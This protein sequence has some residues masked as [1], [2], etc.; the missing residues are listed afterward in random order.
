MSLRSLSVILLWG[1]VF[2]RVPVLQAQVVFPGQEW[3]RKTPEEV[4][5]DPQKLERLGK[6]LGG[7]GCVVKSGYVIHTWGD[8][9]LRK[10]WLSSAKPVLSTLLFFAV[11][12]GKVPAAETKLVDL[13]W[14]LLSK[15]REMQI[16]HL[17][18]MVSGYAR[19]EAPGGAWAYN[20]FAIQLY[21][22]TLFQRIFQADAT[23]VANASERFGA[24]GLQDGLKFSEKA[25]LW[26]SPRDFA[27]IGWFW[28]HKGNWNGK[29]ILKQ[30]FFDR[31]QQPY[32][33]SSLPL[34]DADIDTD[35]Y[36]QIGSYGG[37]SNHFTKA[38]PGI[39][40][41]NWWFNARKEEPGKPYTWPDVPGDAY[42]SLG[43]GGNCSIVIPS[44][45]V[46]VAAA[47]ANWGQV[48]PGVRLS[49]LNQR[50][51]LLVSAVAPETVKDSL[52]EAT[53]VI[54]G[55]LK[56]WH[57]ISLTFDGP[58]SDEMATPNP[59]RD[60]RLIVEFTRP[61]RSL[62]VQGFFA[63]DGNAAETGATAGNKWRVHFAPDEAGAWRYQASLVQGEKVALSNDLKDG[64]PLWTSSGVI[65]VA[66][67]DKKGSDIRALGALRDVGQRYWEFAENHQVYLK[68]G[69]DSPEN[70]LAFADF[71]G[72]KP[73]HKYAP[74]AGDFK[75]GNPTWGEGKGK[76][77]NGALNYLAGHGINGIY[78][79][80]MNVKGDGKDVWPWTAETEH[81]RFDVSKLDQW[82]V[83]FSYMDQLGIMQQIVTQEQE[84]D[85]LLDK[86]ELGDDRT[87]YYRELVAR[88]GHHPALVW[89]LGE[90]NTNTTD[91]LKKFA[92][93]F[94]AVDPYKHPVVVHTFPSQ[95]DKVYGPLLGDKNF[96]GVS[97]QVG[98]PVNCAKVTA[99]WLAK[100]EQVGRPWAAFLDEI[101]P[102]DLGV[103]PD[104]IDP[105]HDEPRRDALW[106]PLMEGGS[107]AEWLFGY[108]YPHTDIDLEDF[109][110]RENMWKQTR[111]AIDFFRDQV[112]VRTLR[113]RHELVS[114][115]TN[116]CLTQPGKFY[117]I[118]LPR[119]GEALLK[120]EAG[121][122]TVSWYNPRA[123]GE[124]I[125]GLVTTVE[126]PGIKSLGLPPADPGKDW[127][128]VVK[129][130]P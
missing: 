109:R 22:K 61:T 70:L 16:A 3:E 44:L 82:E 32:V 4:H 6:L 51:R 17:A 113:A 9:S 1:T 23:A 80:T 74:H 46:V 45:Q 34:S 35:D 101:G 38:G 24:L 107:G 65:D 55:E 29:Q 129:P 15:D 58:Q 8:Q 84:N 36:L 86:G 7:R 31:Y 108:K 67:S 127:A 123:G 124:M 94:K 103:V 83:V 75:A 81:Q 76:N 18:N 28:L 14:P 112:P 19:P 106:R 68:N 41:F 90:E 43:Y 40:G 21:Q 91:Q 48:E 30:E 121:R 50:L 72:T 13:G 69:C 125:S 20:D 88:F 25:R 122:Y 56:K 73:T 71:D 98:K 128:I 115:H 114:P 93:Y 130:A 77:L 49:P 85:Q 92:K 118:Y 126:G 105:D 5:A 39:Y 89:N 63:A 96:S 53:P 47:E 26:A 97:L 116:C 64:T 57:R 12:E 33:A 62:K 79:L 27:R 10:D 11:Q 102:A 120:L 87:L 37:G 78:F 42:M 110:S 59:F 99:T 95:Y 66:P 54:S 117:L 100:S 111:Y 2:C 52:P 60:Y 119:G 104:N